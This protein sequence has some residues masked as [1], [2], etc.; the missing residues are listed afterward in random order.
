MAKDI[1]G[2]LRN[3]MLD[4]IPFDPVG[5]INVTEVGSSIESESIP[6]AGR[7]MRKMTRI[8]ENREGIVLMC[9]DSERS[10][11]KELAERTVDFS[12][13]FTLAS[14]TVYSASGWI[15][16]ENRETQDNRATIQMHPRN[17]W[18]EFIAA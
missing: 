12:M 13:S 15:Q 1:S 18:D 4:G 6:S 9:N 14:G 16:F 5:D 2:T 10:L 17:S 7:N 8:P 11:L 3:V